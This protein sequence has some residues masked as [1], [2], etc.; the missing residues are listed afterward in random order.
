MVK[1]ESRPSLI[2]YS[3][4][5]SLISL[6]VLGSISYFC[7]LQGEEDFCAAIYVEPDVAEAWK[8]RGQVRVAMGKYQQA[9]ADFERAQVLLMV[10]IRQEKQL[11]E[12]LPLTPEVKYTIIVGL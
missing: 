12:T 10:S 1:L 4:H 7:T 2:T 9:L 6:Q 11:I 8:R 5:K 3:K